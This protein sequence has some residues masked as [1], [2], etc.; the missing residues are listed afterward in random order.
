LFVVHGVVDLVRLARLRVVLV[1]SLLLLGLLLRGVVVVCAL[2]EFQ[3][4][5]QVQGCVVLASLLVEQA[6]WVC[7]VLAQ[8]EVLLLGL[9]QA[10][11]RA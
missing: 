3:E 6:L 11:L 5:L 2:Q 9:C 8:P 10:L 7:V 4:L 1:V